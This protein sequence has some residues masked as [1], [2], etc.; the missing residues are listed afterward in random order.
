ME[1]ILNKMSILS[2]SLSEDLEA[3]LKN[4]HLCPHACFINRNTEST[5]FCKAGYLPVLSSVMAHHGEEPPISGDKG[6]GTIFFA[7]CNMGC[8][9]CQNYQISQQ[10]QGSPVSIEDLALK[11]IWLK[12]AGC[13][14][15]NFVSPTI[16]VPQIIKAAAIASKKGLD[17]PMVYNT[18]GYDNP[19]IIEMLKGVID[20]YMPDIRY[21]S[22]NMALKYSKVKKYVE[23]NRASLKEM[24]R[25]VGNL[26]LNRD[27]IAQ[28]GLLVR[29][30]VMPENI[31]SIKESLDFLKEELSTEVYLS[32]MAQYHPEYKACN[33]AGLSRKITLKEYQEVTSYAEKLGF[34]NGWVQDHES[35][36]IEEDMFRPDFRRK[37]VFRYYEEE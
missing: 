36:S 29:L 12:N 26:A 31:G 37:K 27:G 4:C 24:Y 23:N 14:N 28:K 10:H 3:I 11:M 32:I 17:I 16:W 19:E 15:I 8:V 7:H 6:S 25:Q 1:K 2:S 35:L 5:G 21:S 33:Y 9:Y 30:L 13:H 20:I 18:G 34:L 22:N